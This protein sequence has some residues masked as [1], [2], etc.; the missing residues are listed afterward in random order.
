MAN[1][2]FQRARFFALR[3]KILVMFLFIRGLRRTLPT[4]CQIQSDA[5][6]V[7]LNGRV[8]RDFTIRLNYSG[9]GRCLPLGGYDPYLLL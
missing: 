8:I 9:M 1:V 5:F 7:R 6:R 2:D 3:C 4:R